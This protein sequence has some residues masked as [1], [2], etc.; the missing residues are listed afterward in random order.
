VGI[1]A[2]WMLACFRGN[3]K[4][5]PNL[6]GADNEAKKRSRAIDDQ[7]DKDRQ[8]L[9]K[10]EKL[11]LLGAGESGK[12]TF[13]KQMKILHVNGFTNEE[14]ELY[15]NTVYQ[16]CVIVIK[17]LIHGCEQLGIPIQIQENQDL[18]EELQ[19]MDPIHGEIS[20]SSEIAEKITSLWS[21]PG[22]KEAWRRSNEFRIQDTAAYF[23]DNIERI[24]EEDYQPTHD[25][26]LNSRVKTTGV[27]EVDFDVPPSSRFRI[28]DVGG[29]RSERKKWI[30]CFD[31]VTAVMFFV[32]L[33]E[34]DQFLREDET[35]NRMRESLTLWDEISNHQIFKKT[36]M[37][38]F[39]NKLDLFQKK[40][41]H[42]PISTCFKDYKGKNDFDTTSK[43][44]R[45]RFVDLRRENRKYLRVHFTCSTDT[46]SIETVF[47]SVK[48]IIL[49]DSLEKSALG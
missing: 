46:K 32:A 3:S 16:N 36:T 28:V 44:I 34:Y 20:I 17:A 43:Y 7:L 30:N 18:A 12:S 19:E 25:D 27:V 35:V 14:L 9:A 2:D 8:K 5:K 38:L 10:E 41:K 24:S 29:Q 11:L 45:D 6:T 33:S 47:D 42:S 39:L 4:D 26:I 31:K 48:E 22:I 13:L 1:T 37:I 49:Q 23:L 40:I 21:D 15:K